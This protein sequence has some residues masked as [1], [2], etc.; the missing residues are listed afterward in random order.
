MLELYS[1][2]GL[3]MMRR[4]NLGTTKSENHPLVIP[5]LS[6]ESSGILLLPLSV[7]PSE[8]K[9]C[10]WKSVYILRNSEMIL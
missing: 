4:R 9:V 7:R 6:E 3:K 8:R 10:H 5:T 1:L 2:K